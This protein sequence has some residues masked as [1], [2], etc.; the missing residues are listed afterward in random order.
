M[1]VVYS[2]KMMQSHSFFVLDGL[3]YGNARYGQGT[4]AIAMDNVMCLG[5]ENR[6][7]DCP[8]TI[9]VSDSHSEDAG[10]RCFNDAG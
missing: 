5:S 1:S 3:P 10:V 4:G 7:F 6:L 9:P 8:Y 2:D